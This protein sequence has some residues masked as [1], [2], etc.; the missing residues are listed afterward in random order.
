MGW[1]ALV[2]LMCANTPTTILIA[3]MMLPFLFKN[4]F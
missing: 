1:S 3:A 4:I 2:W